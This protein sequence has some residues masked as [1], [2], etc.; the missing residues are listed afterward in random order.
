MLPCAFIGKTACGLHVKNIL[1]CK[2]ISGHLGLHKVCYCE[3]ILVSLA[4][5]LMYSLVQ[6]YTVL[7]VFCSFCS[8]L[9]LFI[10]VSL[11]CIK[12][13]YRHHTIL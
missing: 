2:V 13:Y 10:T 7:I 8:R 3:V 12:L 5:C 11:Y 6:L 4:H 9:Y 1:V